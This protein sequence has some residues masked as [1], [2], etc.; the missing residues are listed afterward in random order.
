MDTG[1]SVGIMVRNNILEVAAIELG[2]A[3][4]A[5]AFPDTRMGRE[6]LKGFLAS[7]HCSIRLAVAGA[8]S[9]G[10]ALALGNFS[11]REVFIVSSA[12]ADHAVALARYAKHAY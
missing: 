6:A 7:R 4:A 10:V 8:A 2:K 3:T 5:I 9:L 11:G 1:I 12:V